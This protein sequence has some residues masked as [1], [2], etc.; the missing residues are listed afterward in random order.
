MKRIDP[1]TFSLLAHGLAAAG[2]LAAGAA[3]F[4]IGARVGGF[5]L[6]LA[7]ALNAAV[8]GALLVVS[9]MDAGQRVLHRL[10]AN[11]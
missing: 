4:A 1:R 7:M 11:A 10:R 9:A 6:G 8:C 3:G 5:V 2:A